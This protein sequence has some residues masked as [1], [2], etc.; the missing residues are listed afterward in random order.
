MGSDLPSFLDFTRP[1]HGY[2]DDDRYPPFIRFWRRYGRNLFKLIQVNL[3]Y[4]IVTLPV[5]VWLMSQINVISTEAGGGVISLLGTLLL[6]YAIKLPTPLIIGL[7]VASIVILGPATA[8]LSYASLNCAWDRPGMF[9]AGFWSAWKE[10]W[11]QA[12][13]I[14]LMD[15]LVLFATLYY[16]VDGN[17][18]FGNYSTMI[19]IL[20][21]LLSLL[22]SLIRV[23]IYP[24]MV[25]IELPFGSLIKNSLILALL[26]PWR[27][28]LVVAITAVLCFACS[29]ADIILIPCFLYSFTAFSAAFLTQPVMDEYLLKSTN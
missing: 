24:I 10:N 20:W 11:K 3:V 2:I 17:A 15:V 9:W 5:Y 7:L 6:Y 25:T 19:Q 16:L 22:Y 27:P 21:I 28:L 26:K 18:I 29:A 4:A 12:L 23:Y 8:A 1:G 13:P 14:G